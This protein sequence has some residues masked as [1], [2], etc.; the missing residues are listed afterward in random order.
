LLLCSCDKLRQT[1]S[2]AAEKVGQQIDALPAPEGGGQAKPVELSPW[3][4]LVDQNQDGYLLRKDLAFPE[5]VTVI[6]RI[7]RR[8]SGRFFTT[9]ELGKNIQMIKGREQ[10]VVR[11]ERDGTVLRYMPHEFS[12][13]VPTTEKAEIKENRVPNPLL[14]SP[15]SIQSLTFNRTASG[16]QGQSTGEFRGMVVVRQLGPVLQDL[17]VDHALAPHAMW[18]SSKRRLKI[19]DQLDLTDQAVGVVLAGQAKGSLHL[20]FESVESIDGHPCGVFAVKG[21]YTRNGFPDF[22]GKLLDEEVSIESGKLWLSLIHPIVLKQ[23]LEM[24]QTYNPGGQGG[25]SGRYQGTVGMTVT[26]E[27]KA[28][29]PTAPA[30]PAASANQ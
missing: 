22:D 3:E 18:F 11:F 9:S 21:S 13:F 29:A 16:W 24:I 28:A 4:K 25:P 23:E 5:Q 8:L 10:S 1:A 26:R 7:E 2:Q 19:G 12:F 6:T 17:L 15:I 27:W 14:A 20:T 30:P